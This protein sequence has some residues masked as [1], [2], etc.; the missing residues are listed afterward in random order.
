[1]RDLIELGAQLVAAQ[2]RPIGVL[3]QERVETIRAGRRNWKRSDRK[4]T[5]NCFM[6]IKKETSSGRGGRGGVSTQD[7]RLFRFFEEACSDYRYAGLDKGG[8][9]RCVEEVVETSKKRRLV[10]GK[11]RSERG[12]RS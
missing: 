6:S 8:V 1:M 3:Q 4:M 2:V 11:C 9:F 10:P 12:G 7:S 5:N